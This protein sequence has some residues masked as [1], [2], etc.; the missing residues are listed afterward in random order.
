V[1][2]SAWLNGHGVNVCYPSAGDGTGSCG[3]EAHVGGDPGPPVGW[4]QCVELA[5]RLYETRGWY[6]ASSGVFAVAKAYQ[7]YAWAAGDT[8]DFTVT[9]NSTPHPSLTPGDMIIT[10]SSGGTNAGH[11][12]IINK[13]AVKSDGS[14]TIDAVEQNNSPTG[15]AT[16]TMT[17]AGLLAR[18]GDSRAITGV[19]HAKKNSSLTVS[20]MTTPRT[21]GTTGSIRVTATDVYG[22][23]IT[24]YTGN[25]HFTSTDTKASLPANYT[26]TAADA[27]THVFAANVILKT[28]GTWSVTATDMGTATLK[29]SQN[30]V[31]VNPAAVSKLVVAGMTSP[32]TAGS[33]GS[34]RVTAT[35]AY[36]NR[37]VGYLG[38]IHFTSTDTKAK[39]PANYKFTA[40]DA[41][42]HVFVAN[43]ILKT[44]GTRSVTA[45]DTVTTTLKGSQT[46]IVVN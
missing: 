22:N 2:G 4:W 31:V 19:V 28:S 25:I 8:A 27:G 34:L 36:G 6:T 43:V 21:A 7:I 13:V 20:G 33:T 42:T 5:Q 11:V 18:P 35:D 45:T 30:G 23:R 1:P 14:A 39:L 24:G 44:I 46:G 38:T 41:G 32:R 37:I 3:G 15:H 17:A 12:A 10:A 29:G 9:P 26:F 16:Y 40:T